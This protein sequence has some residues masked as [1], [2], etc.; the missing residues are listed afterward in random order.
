MA[1]ESDP[2]LT[3]T[4]KS[5]ADSKYSISM[6]AS[7]TILDLKTKLASSEFAD[8]PP[9][10][11]RLI[12]SGR[13]LK[14]GETLSSYKIKDGHTIHLVKGAESNA[15]QNPANQGGDSAQTIPGAGGAA[16]GNVPAN[17]AAGTGAHNP[18]AQLTGARYAGFH[19]LPGMD[20]FGADG[21]MGAPPDPDQLLRLLENP[22]FAQQ[23]N[24][25]MNNPDVINMMRNNP[26]LR[27]NP[28][29]QAVFD[30]PEM[31]RMLMN[32]D[33][34]RMQ[35]Q[36]QRSMGGGPQSAFPAPGATDTTPD[37]QTANRAAEQGAQQQQPPNPFGN[38]GMFG[39]PTG[40]NPFAALFGGN[41]GAVAGGTPA[42]TP[43]VGSAGQTGAPTTP[44]QQ[45]TSPNPASQQQANPFASLFGNMG[46]AGGAASLGA[47]LGGQAGQQG[48][49]NSMMEMANQ[50]MQN[51]EM[52]R[53][54]MNMLGGAGAG[55]PGAAAGGQQQQQQ[56][57][58]APAN[59]FG[60]FN[61]FA[62]G[63]LGGG[64]MGAP[65]S[66]T[67]ADT[68]PPEER[69]AEQLAQLNAMGFY[70]FDRNVRALRMS[71]GSVEG[72]VEALFSGNM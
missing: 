43:P 8:I 15:R 71:G 61:P 4:V 17:I 12:Y 21:G 31:R 11:Q 46:G 1:E 66:Q 39:S 37:G 10:R 68:R 47:G 59:P 63:G 26:M 65:P 36:M 28:M 32:P 64:G 52:M 55:A 14:D 62:M 51:P 20:M 27:N 7:A 16:A 67:P 41:P 70:D 50:M 49:S 72:A 53:A 6:P 42:A 48:G 25:A 56:T 23:M 57:G 69:Y 34:I 33:F 60:A 9:E 22:N 44:S 38:M 30:N 18:L 13:V 54:A 40:A 2:Q 24:E 3:F 58:A 19:Q 35:M 5:S 29:A 45:A